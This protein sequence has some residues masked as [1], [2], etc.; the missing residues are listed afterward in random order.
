MEGRGE[1]EQFLDAFLPFF[2]IQQ[3]IRR[4]SGQKFKI[5][6]VFLRAR[7]VKRQQSFDVSKILN[8][9]SEKRIGNE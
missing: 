3:T 5:L 2:F 1:E 8:F 9:D 6:F 4:N 7:V